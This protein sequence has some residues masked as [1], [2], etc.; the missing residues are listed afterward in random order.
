MSVL[1]RFLSFARIFGCRKP[2]VVILLLWFVSSEYF[3]QVINQILISIR[4][5]TE[6]CRFHRLDEL[7]LFRCDLGE[8]SNLCSF[9]DWAG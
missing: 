7:R 8:I 4:N 5:H 2:E 9:L 6:N 3:A 1:G